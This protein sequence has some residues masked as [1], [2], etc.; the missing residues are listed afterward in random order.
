M[1]NMVKKCLLLAILLTYGLITLAD[2][3]APSAGSFAASAEPVTFNNQI[4]RILQANC[5]S[6]HHPGGVAP[7]P[8]MTYEEAYPYAPAIKAAT[9][10]GRMPLWKPVQGCGKFLNGRRL[11]VEE[12]D[13]IARWVD[14][15]APQGDPSDLPPAREF[16]TG[17]T[18]GQPDLIL[19]PDAPFYPQF[20]DSLDVYRCFPLPTHLTED[21]FVTA[22]EIL[23][24][25]PDLV[26]HV[27]L[28]VDKKG[29]SAA[30]DE[31]EA[32]PGYTCFG[33]PGLTYQNP[34]NIGPAAGWVPGSPALRLPDGVG[35]LLPAGAR[36]VMQVHYTLHGEPG[37]DQTQVGL[38]IARGPIRKQFRVMPVFNRRF[39]IPAGADHY[40][41]TASL[42]LPPR[43]DI[44]AVG[45]L[46]H[47]HLL[48]REIEVNAIHR[49]GTD[50]CLIRIDDWDF[51]WQ[52]NYLYQEPV[53]LP[54]GTRLQ[55]IAYYDNSEN[56]PNNPHSPPRAVRWG[57]GTSD[58][59]CTAFIG[60]TVD[61]EDLTRSRP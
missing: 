31:A 30:L 16:P 51:R 60:Y 35:G 9:Q 20:N 55:V 36:L 40:Q 41:V 8:L 48:G 61:A 13:L 52:G 14:A 23:P 58:E 21:R 15:G 43:F 26:H 29:E 49:D 10:S 54:G 28:T 6:C 34:F 27:L 25:N 56:N 39:T 17:W 18:L 59:M 24:G 22:V 3:L 32:G 46:P 38:Y 37:P 11:T 53:P 4:A 2:G 47:M 45:I 33:G 1:Q 44:H 7:F 50:R 42:R 19:T 12:I 57:E 5:Q